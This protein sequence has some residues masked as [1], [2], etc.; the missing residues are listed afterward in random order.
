MND[1]N[2]AA[3]SVFTRPNRLRPLLA[4]LG[5]L[6]FCAIPA[7]AVAAEAAR[8]FDVPAGEARDTLKRFAAQA[9]VEIAFPS[10]NTLAVRTN[11]VAGRFTPQEAIASLLAGTGLGAAR[12]AKTGAYAVRPEPSGPNAP[13]AP[14]P[15]VVAR[16]PPAPAVASGEEEKLVLSPFAV[17]SGLDTGYIAENS[18][19]GSRINTKLRDTPGSV[20]VF[21]KEFLDDLAITDIKQLTEYSVNTEVDTTARVSGTGQNPSINA[22]N[23]GGNIITRGLSASQGLD[24]FLAIGP[25]DGYR[26]GRYDDSRGPNSILFGIA[27]VGGIVN[28]TS[29]APNTRRDAGTVRYSFGSWA[30]SRVEFDTNVVLKKDRLALLVAAVD[31]KNEGWRNFDFQDK[32]RIF[33]SLLARPTR[34][35]TVTLMGEV[36]RDSNAIMRAGLDTEEMLAWYDNRAARGVDA[37]TVAPT[38]ALPTPAQVALGITTRSG[39]VGGLNRRVTFIENNGVFFD[40]IGTYLSGTYNNAAVRAPDGAAGRTG[41]TLRISDAAIYPAFNNAAGPGMDRVQTVSNYTLNA[42]YRLAEGLYL[43]LGHNY[44][45]TAATLNLM[46]NDSPVFRGDPNRTLGLNGPPN[47]YAGRL[48]FDGDWRRDLAER[49]YRETRASLSYTFDP[50]SRWL[51]RHTLVGLGSQSRDYSARTM[52][53]L[54]L[55][56]R[57]FGT[58]PIGVNNRVTVRNYVT[59]GNYDT[60]RVGDRR[61]LPAAVSFGGRTY[62]TAYA[63]EP[64]TAGTNGAAIQDASSRLAALQSYFW[65][66]RL[67][68]TLGFREDRVKL[69]RLGYRND[70]ILG[71]IV[72]PDPAKH[73]VNRFAGRTQSTGFVLHVT[74]RVSL[75][76]NR[77][78]NQ[79]LPSFNRTVFP[80]GNLAGPPKGQGTDAGLG[81]D[82]FGGRVNAKV[83]YFRSTSSGEAVAFSAG[84]SFRNRNQRVMEA[85]EGVL[86]GPGGPFTAGEWQA[87]AKTYTPG[88]NGSISDNESSGYEARMTANFTRNWRFLFNYSYTDSARANVYDDAIVWYGLTRGPGGLAAQGV[89]QNEAGR[90]VINSSAYTAGGTAAKWLEFGARRPGADPGVLTTS[91]NVTVAQ[92]LFNLVDEINA[93]KED[94]QKRWGLRPHRLSTFTSYDFKTGFARGFSVGG[95]WRWRSANIIGTD[96]ARKEITG[97]ALSYW[98]LMIRHTRKFPALPGT[99]SIQLNVNNV[100]DNSDPVPQRLLT[101][102]PGYRLPG[103]RGVAY[104]RLDLVD[105]REFRFSTTYSF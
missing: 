3:A 35:L 102:D 23:L 40:A 39:T 96:S 82:L 16:P 28:Q 57:P 7:P 9:Q 80:D 30:R 21:T 51:G 66:D 20:S 65:R 58:D 91:A 31:Q 18:L 88:V 97:R 84:S 52:S 11:A 62:A 10:E 101:N 47:P 72:D 1:R 98:D 29:K 105:P 71:D 59:E 42:D 85:F 76:A 32:K 26:V 4:G 17:V 34:R 22:T 45:R 33:G 49:N 60:Y 92:E 27:A 74:D 93:T 6:F 12:D 41:A 79:A 24:Y 36:G 104:G 54:V 13:R 25:G 89:G 87:L 67:V 100:F 37:V 50:K 73:T 99:F 83:V 53:W 48:Y 14:A 86:A 15:P 19:A 69:S 77:S 94:Q 90:F 43:N 81:F 95:G 46:V 55:A 68:T 70:P 2:P 8:D 44:Q 63:N 56:G 5:A 78:T 75:L 61:S 38:A 103:G 64:G